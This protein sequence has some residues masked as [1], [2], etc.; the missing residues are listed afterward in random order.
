MSEEGGLYD[1]YFGL[2]KGKKDNRPLIERRMSAEKNPALRW[3]LYML[4][5]I[6][7]IRLEDVLGNVEVCLKAVEEFPLDPLV[8]T[9]LSG[10]YSYFSFDMERALEE[11]NAAVDVARRTNQFRRQVLHSKARLL[12]DM[13]DYGGLE[14]CL[15]EIMSE[16]RSATADIAKEDDF[17]KELPD[18]A[19]SD[20]VLRAYA[21]FMA[22]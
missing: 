21:E 15:Q 7:S 4:L 8:R 1:W 14:C 10:A 22:R 2:E 20:G 19:I 3:E 13:K 17:L 12:R 6:E 16:P 5:R 11:M 18:G 9:A